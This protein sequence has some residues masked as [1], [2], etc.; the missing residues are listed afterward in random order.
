MIRRTRIRISTNT[1]ARYNARNT[2]LSV[3]SGL[4]HMLHLAQQGQVA[5]DLRVPHDTVR[6]VLFDVRRG[7]PHLPSRAASCAVSRHSRRTRTGRNG[8]QRIH[9]GRAAP[10]IHPRHAQTC[11]LRQPLA[12]PQVAARTLRFRSGERPACGGEFP[13]PRRV[14][15]CA[16]LARNDSL[17]GWI[18]RVKRRHTSS[19]Q[20]RIRRPS[21]SPSG[22]MTLF[23]SATKDRL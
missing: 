21:T 7:A 11:G 3:A 10:A 16:N 19:P 22:V 1:G 20:R 6:K 18:G 12:R 8:S 5:N 23:R 15:S 13:G 17:A 2:A 14:A 9:A 4:R